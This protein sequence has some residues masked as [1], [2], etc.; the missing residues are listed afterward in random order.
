M[1]PTRRPRQ[2]IVFDQTDFRMVRI[3]TVLAAVLYPALTVVPQLVQWI[4]GRPLTY[5]GHVRAVG[6]EVSGAALPPAQVTYSDEVVWTI[7]GASPTQWLGSLLLPL[8]TTAC[9]IAGAVLLLRLLARAGRGEPFIAGSVRLL[10]MLAVVILAYGVLIPFLP[11]LTGMMVAWPS[12]AD[13][14]VAG[15]LSPFSLLPLVVGLLV[16]ALAECF[17][18]GTRLRNDVEGLV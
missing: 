13:G 15:L 1:T 8:V 4:G 11:T 2:P 17:R 14:A 18:V 12:S 10:R 5:L 9:I 3:L 7:P 6:P 16:A